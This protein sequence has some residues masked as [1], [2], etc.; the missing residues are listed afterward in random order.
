MSALINIARTDGL[1][2]ARS[3]WVWL[4]MLAGPILA[5][6]WIPGEGDATSVIVV[7]DAAPVLSSSTL[8]LSLGIVVSVL[9]LPLGYIFLRAG[10]TRKQPW[11]VQD[12]TAQSRVTIALGHWLADIALFAL[13]LLGLSLAGC[14]LAYVMLPAKAVSI[15]EILFTLWIT[16]LPSLGLMAGV[17]ALFAS[18]RFTRGGW[19]D[20][21]FFIFWMVGITVGGIL[22]T[23]SNGSAF[24]DYSGAFAPVA[25]NAIGDATNIGIGASPVSGK[26][27]A[28]NV[29]TPMLTADYIG[30]RIFWLGMGAVLATIA[31]WIYQTPIQRPAKKLR[32]YSKFLDQVPKLIPANR[33]APPAQAARFPILALI[34]TNAK[35]ILRSRVGIMLA[36]IIALAGLAL[37]FRT[38]ISPAALL[39]LIL[40]STAHSARSEA[41]GMRG[42]L[43]TQA[44]PPWQRRLIDAMTI[45][46]LSIAM[47]LPAQ[48]RG[49]FN[50]SS[51]VLVGLVTGT[52]LA[53]VCTGFGVL[54]RSAFAGRMLL[55]IGWYV[56]ISV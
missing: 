46:A 18:L 50:S 4:L 37:P 51:P 3:P 31:G 6:V 38:I 29:M 45:I 33:A 23:E 52:V 10:P 14:I 41:R 25:A 11:Q 5:R 34:A 44:T 21:G 56:Y 9:L 27:I 2:F 8:G 24:V 35:L 12:V 13:L 48:F 47:A 19:G 26:T 42:L 28:L 40:G 7:N 17:R 22:V 20:F 15:P 49:E 39:L 54:T 30:S 32:W 55:L 36:I 16:A 1:R 53:L 43:A